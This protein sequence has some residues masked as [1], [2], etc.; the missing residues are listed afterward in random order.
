MSEGDVEALLNLY[1]AEAVLLNEQGETRQG[2]ENLREVLAPLA[3][4]QAGFTYNIRQIIQTGDIA[5]M[6][7][8]WKVSAPQ[9][10]SQYANVPKC[11][12]S[13]AAT[14]RWDVALADRRSVY[15]WQ[16][17][18]VLKL[19]TFQTAKKE[20]VILLVLRSFGIRGGISFQ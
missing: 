19:H 9:P 12:G 15:H 5:L 3:A 16:A 18:C 7:T 6:H 11:D 2:R 4:A 17:S 14:A 10:M 13:R 1:D 20:E 8:D